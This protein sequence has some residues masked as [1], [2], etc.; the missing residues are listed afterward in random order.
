MKLFS[1]RLNMYIYLE[2]QLLWLELFFSIVL[3][4]RKIPF[5]IVKWLYIH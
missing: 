3:D 5:F 4:A 2:D 1:I